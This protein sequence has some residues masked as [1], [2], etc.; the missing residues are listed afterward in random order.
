[1]QETGG[2][3]S[4]AGDERLQKY[5]W[6]EIDEGERLRRPRQ[7][8]QVSIGIRR[9]AYTES[10]ADLLKL[11]LTGFQIGTGLNVGVGQSLM[12][13]LPGYK[14]SMQQWCGATTF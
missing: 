7:S 10:I 11:S 12:I 1:M 6:T 9:A 13:Y 8:L 5:G 4:E 3:T 2:P 14:R